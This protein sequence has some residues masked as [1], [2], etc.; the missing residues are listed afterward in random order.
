KLEKS[1]KEMAKFE[2]FCFKLL[3]HFKYPTQNKVFSICCNYFHFEMFDSFFS[4]FKIS[5]A[6]IEFKVRLLIKKMSVLVNQDSSISLSE[7]EKKLIR[8]IE[9]YKKEGIMYM[10]I[11][12]SAVSLIEGVNYFNDFKNY[13]Q[14]GLGIILAT[15]DSIGQT[16]DIIDDKNL[17]NS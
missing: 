13:I 12:F 9:C 17:H 2:E 7:S 6:R 15:E 14:V 4:K 3:N 16:I 10:E 1:G 8:F 5:Y 11:L